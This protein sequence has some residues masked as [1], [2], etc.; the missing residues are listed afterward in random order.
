VCESR[1]ESQ[2]PAVDKHPDEYGIRL[3]DLPR[4]AGQGG[5]GGIGVKYSNI[6]SI[7]KVAFAVSSNRKSNCH[8][9]QT[10]L[11]Q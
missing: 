6:T 10:L 11:N 1:A 5:K 8:G 2:G 7:L 9:L 4:R 3:D